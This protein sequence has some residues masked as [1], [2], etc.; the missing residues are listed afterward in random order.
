MK[1]VT[2]CQ[3]ITWVIFPLYLTVIFLIG[4]ATCLLVDQ[5]HIRSHTS[6]FITQ[7]SRKVNANNNLVLGETIVIK[8]SMMT[9]SWWGFK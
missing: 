7:G 3:L 6:Q 9:M 2:K 4:W 5:A 8:G 1:E